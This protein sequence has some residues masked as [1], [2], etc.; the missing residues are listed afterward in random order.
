MAKILRQ[1]AERLL[2]DV[3]EEYAFRCSDGGVFRNMRELGVALDNMTD[4]TFA[5]HSSQ[6]KSDFGSWVADM[7]KDE[8]LARD[9]RKSANRAQGAKSVQ[10][11]IAFLNSKL[12]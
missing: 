5:Y 7:I 12:V 2:G 3:P 10:N 9:L 8:K 4:E 11:R 1:D 6:S